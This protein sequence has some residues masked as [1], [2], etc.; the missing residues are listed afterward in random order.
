MAPGSL[1]RSR[2]A[3]RLTVFGRAL[4]KAS[5]KKGRVARGGEEELV[6]LRPAEHGRVVGT[7]RIEEVFA[8]HG[9]CRPFCLPLWGFLCRTQSDDGQRMVAHAVNHHLEVF[10]RLLV[11][12]V[13]HQLLGQQQIGQRVG[14]LVAHGIVVGGNGFLGEVDAAVAVGHLQRTLSPERAILRTRL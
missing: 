2:T 14:L 8:L 9:V 12:A 10:R 11:L 1:V 4:R 5:V 13:L 6:V 7:P 3:M